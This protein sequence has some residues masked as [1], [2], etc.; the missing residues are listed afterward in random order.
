MNR[1]RLLRLPLA[2]GAY[3]LL[4]G[5]TPYGQWVVY[6]RKHLLIGCHRRDPRTY[7]LARQT[8]EV[9][10][11][12][13]PDASARVAR[14][15][16]ARRIASLLGTD[17]LEVAVLDRNEAAAMAE[18]RDGFAPFGVVNLRLLAPV[19]ERLLLS[20]AGFPNR[21]AWLVTGALLGSELAPP[22]IAWRDSL[23][24]WHP[25]SIAFAEGRSAPPE[26]AA[27]AAAQAR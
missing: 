6:R 21:H 8:V 19:G 7:E 3:L 13:L 2:L 1:R 20:H 10:D 23:L 22:W 18:G 25:G 4:G 16:D 17:Q 27:R 26:P 11:E 15:P 12:H 9:L 14:A 24:P 5:H